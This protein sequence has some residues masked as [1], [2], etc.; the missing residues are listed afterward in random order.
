MNIIQQINQDILDAYKDLSSPRKQFLSNRIDTTTPKVLRCLSDSSYT[1]DADN[2]DTNYD[3]CSQSVFND[4]DT[5]FVLMISRVGPYAC[6]LSVNKSN[7]SIVIDTTYNGKNKLVNQMLKCLR[8]NAIHC[9]GIEV[10][11]IAVDLRTEL[12]DPKLATIYNA[13]FCDNAFLPWEPWAE[14]SRRG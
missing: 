4:E 3:V 1:L 8:T 2:T 10:L 12:R 13:L 5:T 11:G 14:P 7:S 6:I 9:L